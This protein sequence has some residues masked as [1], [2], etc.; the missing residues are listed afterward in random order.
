[1]VHV[2]GQI[3]LTPGDSGSLVAGGIKNETA[4]L[5]ENI[6]NILSEANSS[7]DDGL[8]CTVL[9]ADL[10]NE[11]DDFN[12]VYSTYFADAP[13]ARAAFEVAALPKNARAEVKCSAL[14]S[15]E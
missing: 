15:N 3:G 4:Q 8:E 10:A 1:M 11:Y 6:R 2:A 9:M 7:F 14:C 5:M 12:S 13:P